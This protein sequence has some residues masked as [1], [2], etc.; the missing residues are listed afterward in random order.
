ML[1]L[2]FLVCLSELPKEWCTISRRSQTLSQREERGRS[3]GWR[4]TM[5]VQEPLAKTRKAHRRGNG[6]KSSWLFWQ[7]EVFKRVEH[8]GIIRG[9]RI[10]WH[11][12]LFCFLKYPL[13]S[14]C[15]TST[16]TVPFFQDRSL[17]CTIKILGKVV[18]STKMFLVSEASVAF[19][20]M[21][22][23]TVWMIL[24]LRFR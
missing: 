6:K 19:R 11:F 18:A 15:G 9:R 20:N 7:T 22:G 2:I 8:L 4:S 16:P 12:N 14:S 23:I 3:G 24:I 10:R 13:M 5:A 17:G 21:L 1:G